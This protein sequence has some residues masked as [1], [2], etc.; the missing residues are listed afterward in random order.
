M[1]GWDE[2][3]KLGPR[4][5]VYDRGQFVLN[6]E[7][8]CY[9]V[10][11]GKYCGRAKAWPGHGDADHQFVDSLTHVLELSAEIARLVVELER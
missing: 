7:S 9:C 4:G 3:P 11:D 6:G 2:I 8:Y 1:V 5:I 10:M